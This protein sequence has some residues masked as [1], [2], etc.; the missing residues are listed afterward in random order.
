VEYIEGCKIR[1]IGDLETEETRKLARQGLHIA[2]MING[3]SMR[4]TTGIQP[5]LFGY[6][7]SGLVGYLNSGVLGIW[8]VFDILCSRRY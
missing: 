2:A 4:I 8:L 3:S 1:N 6:P 5:H 7:A